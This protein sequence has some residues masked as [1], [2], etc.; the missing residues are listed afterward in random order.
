MI[1][2]NF[3]TGFFV[4]TSVG[5]KWG[6]GGVSVYLAILATATTRDTSPSSSH[7][8]T[9]RRSPPQTV[10]LSSRRKRCWIPELPR[11]QSLAPVYGERSQAFGHVCRHAVG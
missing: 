7:F 4:V 1:L 8:I 11:Y 9:H 2:L 3:L 5:R 10:D 6:G